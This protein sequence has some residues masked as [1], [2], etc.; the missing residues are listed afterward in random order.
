MEESCPLLGGIQVIIVSIHIGAGTVV[1]WSFSMS[2]SGVV[3]A[4][5]FGAE[6]GF[7]C[8]TVGV[9]RGKGWHGTLKSG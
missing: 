4:V 1:L 6:R 9:K 5:G 7:G 2:L 8:F 3:W